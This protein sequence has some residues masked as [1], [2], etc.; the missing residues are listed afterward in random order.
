MLRVVL[1]VVCACWA[2]PAAASEAML[3]APPPAWARPLEITAPALDGEGPPLRVLLLDNQV[4][5]DEAGVAQFT[6][7]FY[8]VRDS[9]ALGA[10]G[11][12]SISWDPAL[13]TVTLHRLN[14]IR[15]GQVIDVLARQEFTLLRR[16]S[17]LERAMLDG[18]LTA[19]LQPEGVR[20]GDVLEL[21]YTSVRL[22]P[23]LQGRAEGAVFGPVQG[24]A[25]RVRI[26]LTWPQARP[27][28]WKAAD[29]LPKAQVGKSGGEAEVIVDMRDVVPPK[30]SGDAP[31]RFF[32]ARELLFTEFGDWSEAAALMAPLYA[33][34]SALAADSPLRRE[35]G[36]IRAASN[37]P[38]EQAAAALRLVQ[39]EVRYLAL[40]LNQGGYVPTAAD[41]TWRRRYGDCKA[42]T[43]LLLALLG[44]LG[45]DA[46]P[47]LVNTLAGDGLDAQLPGLR[48]FNHVLVR[49]TI[50]GEAYWMDGARI[51]DLALE[52]LEPPPYLWA[53][54]VREAG[55]K[56]EP[57][58]Q[59]ALP[60]P[61]MA[62]L[63]ELDASAG[64]DTP[65]KVRGEM[66][67]SGD[68]A[69]QS[70]LGLAAMP[71][72]DREKALRE[73]WDDYDWIEIKSVSFAEDP[74][75]GAMTLRMTGEG[76]LVWE[77][78]PGRARRL[79]IGVAEFGA[80]S[81]EREA[82]ASHPDAP[83]LVEGHPF[84]GTTTVKVTL[85]HA[86]EGFVLEAPA[87]D[88][89]A[90]GMAFAREG[91]IE[92][93]VA[94]VR[95]TQRTTARELPAAEAKAANAALAELGKDQVLIRTAATYRPTDKDIETWR[96]HTPETAAAYIDRGGLFLDVDRIDLALADFEKAVEL[97]PE[98][99]FSYA[100]RALARI[101]AGDIEAAKA[102]VAKAQKLD[103]RNF[104]ALHGVGLIAMREARFA[105]AAAA[106][107]RAADLQRDNLWAHRLRI[108]AFLAMNAYDEAL[109]EADEVERI[110]PGVQAHQTRAQ[111][112]R[113][114][115]RHDEALAE[116]DKALALAPGHDGLHLDRAFALAHAGRRQEADAALDRAVALAPTATN[117]LT[118]A[119]LRRW[120]PAA[121]RLAD[122]E[123]A[124]RLEPNSPDVA[125]ARAHVF[126]DLGRYDEALAVLGPAVK[127]WPDRTFFVALRADT[128]ARAGRV[129]QASADF[130]RMRAKAAG[131]A[132]ALNELCWTQAIRN[133]ALDDALA[134]C[135]AALALAPQFAAAIDSR[136]FVLLR[137]GRL[138][139]AAE[140]Y[141]QVLRLRPHQAASLFGR[142]VTRLR[143]G[144]AAEGQADLA[145]ARASDARIEAEFAGYGIAPPTDPVAAGP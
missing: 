121:E 53:L 113:T 66:T 137:M 133:L 22:D 74:K 16:E 103:S 33:R 94:I 5:V 105:D 84:H 114:Q 27:L 35:V 97:E 8:Q 72:A 36:R 98:S 122:I 45:I 67:Y 17:N 7:Q 30:F 140:T 24:T 40:T 70:R 76:S 110:A 90:G 89:E 136:A 1:A 44:E 54:P 3:K 58:V 124:D 61:N 127:A 130:A 68:L 119:R 26:R 131:D 111:I 102:D 101:S 42:K 75:T 20:V 15:G 64:L 134:D 11:S 69:I 91:R 142:G 141:D 59:P 6:H 126:A 145:R 144:Q 87:V 19:T 49:A 63:L 139:E 71:A 37:D 77:T 4:H 100:N 81:Y 112:H 12:V 18:I 129:A 107:G 128:L 62:V 135:D 78:L 118:R 47:V 109:R 125:Y 34:A 120:A 57:I 117:H 95:A 92:N 51:G 138:E 85:P 39:Q 83:Y 29:G 9:S 31:L 25:D 2:M 32:P 21:A 14:I 79:R 80:M 55:S 132:V 10:V 73:V 108:D 13:D 43:V 96:A 46:E 65:S 99:A 28:R 56:L 48:P 82:E 60:R 86:G 52:G 143:L 38:R 106:F 50:E 123:A 23:V 115:A 88:R 116:L 104:V 93:G 41:E